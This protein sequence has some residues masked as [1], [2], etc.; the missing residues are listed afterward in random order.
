M[1]PMCVGYFHTRTF[2]ERDLNKLSL[3]N[4][5]VNFQSLNKLQQ[6]LKRANDFIIVQINL[7]WSNLFS[8]FSARGIERQFNYR[9]KVYT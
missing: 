7:L 5:Q 2:S 9:M 4:K 3:T 1:L 8:T 6:L